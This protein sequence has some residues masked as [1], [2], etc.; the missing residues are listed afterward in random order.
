MILGFP[1]VVLNGLLGRLITSLQQAKILGY[2]GI[3]LN[4]F[5]FLFAFLSIKTARIEYFG[6]STA[7][8]YLLVNI[9]LVVRIRDILTANIFEK[10]LSSDLKIY[11]YLVVL[12]FFHHFFVV[13][14]SVGIAISLFDICSADCAF[15]N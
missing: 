2:A 1:F 10:I 9:F 3:L 12:F 7:V 13:Y 6:Y 14:F 4:I 11:I 5:L 8:S 15:I